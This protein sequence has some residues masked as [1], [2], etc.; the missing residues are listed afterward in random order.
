LIKL[1]NPHG[2]S[3]DTLEW[4]GDWSDE[5]DQWTHHAKNVLNYE[6]QLDAEKLD[7]VF[8]MNH[9]DFISN[10]KYFYSCRV[11]SED[12]GWFKKEIKS[13]WIGV[14]SAG[15]PGKLKDIPQFKI[16]VT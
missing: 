12:E 15:F 16:K 5:S 8:W 2:A 13:E 14:T 7:G 6:P 11:L 3:Y 9:T 1:R 4:T 10:F